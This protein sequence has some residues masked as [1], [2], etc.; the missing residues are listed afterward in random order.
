[1]NL[2][3]PLFFFASASAFLSLS[4]SEFEKD[5]SHHNINASERESE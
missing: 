4:L 5:P 2:P 3:T 1:M